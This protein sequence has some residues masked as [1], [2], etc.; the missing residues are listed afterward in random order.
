MSKIEE[1]QEIL[2][3]LGLPAAQQNEMS[4]LTLLA[5]CKVKEPDSWS[6]ASRQS[7]GVTKGIMT[8]VA[9]NYSKNYAPNTREIVRR[10]VLHPFVQGRIAD[11]NPDEQDLP[12]NSPKAHYALSDVALSVIQKYGTAA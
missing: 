9:E 2:K 11:Y 6:H 7:L 3:A 5:L 8:F 12:V 1:A 4:A 10:Q